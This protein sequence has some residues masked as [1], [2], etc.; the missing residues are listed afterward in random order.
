LYTEVSTVRA[1][2][3]EGYNIGVGFSLDY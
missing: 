2:G 1:D 3:L